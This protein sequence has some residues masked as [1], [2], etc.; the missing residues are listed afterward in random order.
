MQG[1]L[2]FFLNL[3]FMCFAHSM[4]ETCY[5]RVPS[6]MIHHL[7]KEEME[8]EEKYKIFTMSEKISRNADC[9]F[10]RIMAMTQ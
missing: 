3:E 5:L 2:T 6:S 7:L 10:Y 8:E 9:I 1:R 4:S